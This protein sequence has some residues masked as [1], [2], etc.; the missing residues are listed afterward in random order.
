M[1]DWDHE[2]DEEGANVRIDFPGE[3]LKE[4]LTGDG[5]ERTDEDGH[6]RGVRWS[7]SSAQCK[8]AILTLQFT[9]T[10]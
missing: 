10:V 1:V 4:W 9:L 6:P 2:S 7:T 3:R 8:G 5:A